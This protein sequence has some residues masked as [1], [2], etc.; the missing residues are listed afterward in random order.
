MLWSERA[1]DS[2]QFRNLRETSFSSS[3]GDQQM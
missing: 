3:I 1:S 2:I